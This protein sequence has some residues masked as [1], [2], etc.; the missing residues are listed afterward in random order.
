MAPSRYP[1]ER[2]GF[3]EEGR[4]SIARPGRRIIALLIDWGLAILIGYPFFHN[5]A[6]ANLGIF[7]LMQIVFIPTIGGSI[8][9]RLLGLRLV[10]LSGGWIGLW[11][12]IVR[13]LLLAIVVPA[14]IWDSDQRG[15]HDKIAG[16]VLLR[17]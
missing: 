9:H 4:G 2:L 13:T 8:G 15:F 16:T 1:G 17:L 11:R 6:W 7:V 14:L 10:A 3:P 12:P 5:D